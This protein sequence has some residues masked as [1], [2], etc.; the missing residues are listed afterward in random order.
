LTA[1][2]RRTIKIII[3]AVLV[4]TPTLWAKGNDSL[5][6]ILNRH[7][8]AVGGRKAIENIH[9]VTSWSQVTY[10]GL[11]G[12]QVL[13]MAVPGRFRVRLTIGGKTQVS[14]YDGTKGW[15]TDSNNLTRAMSAAELRPLRGEA[16]FQEFSYLFADPSSDEVVFA[17]DTTISG[18]IYHALSLYP[19]DSDSMRIFIGSESGLVEY[20]EDWLTGLRVISTF[21]DYRPFD[22]LMIPFA[23]EAHSVNGPYAITAS[24]DSI[25]INQELPDSIFTMPGTRHTN[26]HFP[27]N[28]DSL[29]IPYTFSNNHISVPVCVNGSGPYWFLL[30]SGAGS[31]LLSKKLADSLGIAAEGD[32]PMRGVGGF[33]KIGQGTIDSLSLGGLTLDVTTVHILDFDTIGR[34]PGFHAAGIIGY[35]L[36]TRFPVLIDFQSR[37]L[38]IFDS[39]RDRLPAL[40][41]TLAVEIYAQ[42]PIIISRINDIQVRLALDLGSQLG[43]VVRYNAPVYDD[44]LAA[45]GDHPQKTRI[46]GAGGMHSALLG[47]ADVMQ[48][49]STTIRRPMIVLSEGFETFPFPD[50]I[51]GLLGVEILKQFDLLLDYPSHRVLF[52]HY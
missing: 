41:D 30:D 14:G 27:G 11:R 19:P 32:L 1:N 36:F 4:S 52:H 31:T 43:V 29:V 17:G 23:M 25:R 2:T 6:A 5:S 3:L 24:L 28:A 15:I 26:Y 20:R 37:Q 35:D 49:G 9:T 42:L 51:E 8:Q 44:L 34:T 50:Y 21:S 47:T 10:S 7:A 16:Y 18:N 40:S 39:R 46:S 48:F 13:D 45:L 22:G 33:G 38:T 12:E